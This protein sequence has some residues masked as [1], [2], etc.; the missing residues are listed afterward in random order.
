MLGLGM[1]LGIG[2]EGSINW[3]ASLSKFVGRPRPSKIKL[4]FS[5]NHEL[6]GDLACE[7]EC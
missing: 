3:I 7:A 4:T 5:N 2:L 6:L 1:G